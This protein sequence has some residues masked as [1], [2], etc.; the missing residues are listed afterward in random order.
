MR[1]RLTSGFLLEPEQNTSA[2][3]VLSGGQVFCDAGSSFSPP[4]RGGRRRFVIGDWESGAVKAHSFRKGRSGPGLVP[5]SVC[6][7]RGRVHLAL[8]FL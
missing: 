3:V 8:R 6:P 2:I 7:L 4:R 5:I 1:G